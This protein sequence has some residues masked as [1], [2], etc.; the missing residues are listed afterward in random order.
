MQL[1]K[2]CCYTD[3]CQGRLL[4]F[5]FIGLVYALFRPNIAMY[6]DTSA[7]KLTSICKSSDARLTNGHRTVNEHLVKMCAR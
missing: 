3:T 2:L 7:V 6:K 5:T 4:F 1:I